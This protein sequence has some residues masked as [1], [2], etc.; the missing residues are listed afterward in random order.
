MIRITLPLSAYNTFKEDIRE[1]VDRGFLA[2]IEGNN[3]I[4]WTD[5]LL[6]DDSDRDA[7][8][9]AGGSVDVFEGIQDAKPNP[10]TEPSL[11]IILPIEKYQDFKDDIRESVD[12]GYPIKIIDG[13]LSQKTNGLFFEKADAEAIVAAGGDVLNW[14]TFLE[15]VPSEP[16]LFNE[17]LTWLEYATAMSHVP[18]EINGAFYLELKEVDGVTAKPAS[19]I[20]NLD[21]LTIDEV[22]ALQLAAE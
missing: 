4:Q 12:R 5:G 13:V 7:I 16:C 17:E 22:R 19:E 8:I 14:A 6:F 3:I 2:A 9:A 10:I 15:I 20:I 1:S 11:E 21:Y 18:T